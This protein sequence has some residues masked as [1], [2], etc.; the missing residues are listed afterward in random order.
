MEYYIGL[1]V[2]QR[3]TAICVIDSKALLSGSAR[4]VLQNSAA[5]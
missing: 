4:V 2:S 5:T 3:H 1:D